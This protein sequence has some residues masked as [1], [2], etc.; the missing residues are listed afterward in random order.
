MKV[1]KISPN[2]YDSRSIGSDANQETGL[3]TDVYEEIRSIGGDSVGT[4]GTSVEDVLG[5]AGVFHANHQGSSPPSCA[6][7]G[8]SP[9]DIMP[10]NKSSPTSSAI[11]SVQAALSALQAGQ[12]SLN[13]VNIN[14][15]II[16]ILQ[17]SKWCI[18]IYHHPFNSKELSTTLCTL[19]IAYVDTILLR[20]LLKHYS[21]LCVSQK[22]RLSTT[23]WDT[24]FWIWQLFKK[25]TSTTKATM[26]YAL[27]FNTLLTVA[28]NEGIH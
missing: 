18:Y 13:Q 1:R 19:H 15:K 10:K 28:V 27:F 24:L 20:L 9:G 12:M 8:S 25:T 26:L 22:V 23:M 6:T 3:L 2:D 14:T 17:I 5:A 11:A 16:N 21:A 4:G 7:S